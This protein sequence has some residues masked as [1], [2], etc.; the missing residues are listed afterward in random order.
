MRNLQLKAEFAA[1][2]MLACGLMFT[3]CS[4]TENSEEPETVTPPSEN[5]GAGLPSNVFANGTP[6]STPDVKSITLDEQGRVSQ[7]EI[8]DGKV[9][10]TYAPATKATTQYDAVMTI[11]TEYNSRKYKD[12]FYLS[13]ENNLVVSALEKDYESNNTQAWTFKYN[14][15][16]RLIYLEK[17]GEDLY[18]MSYDA[19]GDLTKVTFKDLS[20]TTDTTDTTEFYIIEYTSNKIPA[21]IENKGC[22]MEWDHTFDIDMDN[23][24]YAYMAGLLGK[25]TTHLPL[26]VREED[27]TVLTMQW[28]LNQNNYPVQLQVDYSYGSPSDNFSYTW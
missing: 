4:N 7:L 6:K 3:G 11:E 19:N 8:R 17:S 24:K 13:I 1:I 28:K 27:G 25:A 5:S 20:E 21:A 22:I 15:D 2:C 16:D 26:A 14:S 12:E 10:F 23:M 9:S 18:N